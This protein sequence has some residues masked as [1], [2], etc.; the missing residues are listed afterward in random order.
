MSLAQR[1][2]PRPAAYKCSNPAPLTRPES[3]A[4]CR[5]RFAP[6]TR[7]QHKEC[8]S[9]LEVEINPAQKTMLVTL[10]KVQKGPEAG[11]Q[12]FQ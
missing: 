5:L 8:S 2:T 7:S 9:L 11:S 1:T 4:N 10:G 6:S 12:T 3:S